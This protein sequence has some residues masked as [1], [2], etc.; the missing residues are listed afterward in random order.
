MRSPRRAILAGEIATMKWNRSLTF[1]G[2]LAVLFV[3]AGAL[4]WFWTQSRDLWYD[5]TAASGWIS[6][7][8]SRNSDERKYAISK[9]G[10]TAPVEFEVVLPA[11]VGALKDR[12]ASVR[13]EAASALWRYLVE[14]LH[15]RG[16][17]MIDHLRSATRS[18]I[19][20][21]EQDRDPAV[22]ATAAFATASLLHELKDAG[23]NPDHSGAGDPLDP[24]TLIKVLNALLE[25]D[26]TARLS[27]LASYRRLGPIDEPAPKALLAALDDSSRIVRIEAMLAI[28]EFTSGMDKAVPVLLRDAESA[29]GESQFNRWQHLYPLRQAAE[30]LH[31]SPAVIPLLID[32]LQSPN[33]DVREV[34]VVLLLHLGPAGRPATP[35]LI[36]ATRSMIQSVKRSREHGEDPFFSDFAATV[37]QIAPPEDAIAV[38]SE[39]L[40][41]DHPASGAHAA[42]FLGKLGPKGGAAVPILLKALKDAGDPPRGRLLDEYVHAILRSLWDI[43]PGAGLPKPMADEVIEVLSRALEDPQDFIRRTAADA[44]GDF[45]PRAARAVPRLRA[46]SQNVQVPRDTREAAAL[47][48]Q[49]IELDLDPGDA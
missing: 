17:A 8:H 39:A 29:A 3:A 22:C 49:K 20:V 43:A 35:A 9:L 26:P 42:W 25:R 28:T 32:G 27:L 10:S 12:V 48:L 4:V 15:Y 36:S 45:G 31:P 2:R 24:K 6:R 14:S 47:S 18:L 44:L 46:L 13:N 34:A 37:V 5:P 11:L 7:A 30:R 38:L 33:P 21:V 16:L 41:R 23:I 40:D 19:E 1:V